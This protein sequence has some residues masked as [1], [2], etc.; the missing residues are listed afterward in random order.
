MSVTP[1][2]QLETLR[3]QIAATH[4]RFVA[5]GARLA[6]AAQAIRTSGSLPADALLR[7]VQ[8]A[9]HEFHAVRA[10]VLDAAASLEL[11]PRV[12]P[13]EIT[14]LRDL[15]PLMDAVARAADHAARRRQLD[16]ARAIAFAVLNRVPA[17]VHREESAFAPLTACQDKARALRAAIT[18][19]APVDL[20]LEARAWARAVTPFAALLALI[21][22]PP[23]VE[24][25]RWCELQE[26]VAAAFGDR[27][28]TA[29]ARGALTLA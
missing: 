5:L 23:A 28:A 16:A 27:L 19:A 13:R 26:T 1:V 6:Q 4:A 18:G 15:A 2:V 29:A 14:M 21:D 17:I 9:A 8:D 24:E 20:E 12:Q 10:A 3:R 22:G 7:E 11:L 25:T